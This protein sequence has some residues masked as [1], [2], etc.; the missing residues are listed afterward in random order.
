M[1]PEQQHAQDDQSRGNDAQIPLHAAIFEARE[2]TAAARNFTTAFVE[3]AVHNELVHT[4]IEPAQA[5]DDAQATSFTA[6]PKIQR[7]SH[8]ANAAK[9]RVSAMMVTS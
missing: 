7:S 2:Q 9:K 5:G 8:A 6:P 4:R 3:A 1:P